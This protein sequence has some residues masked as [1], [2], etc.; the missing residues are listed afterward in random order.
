MTFYKT[1][2]SAVALL[3]SITSFANDGAFYAAGNHL[4]PMY[5]TEISVRKEILTIKRIDATHVQITV[6]YE[7]FN[8]KKDKTIEVGFEAYSPSGDVNATPQKGQHPYMKGFTVNLNGQAVPWKVAIVSDSAY[9]KNGVFKTKTLAAALKES[10]EDRNYVEFFY[11]YHFKALFKEGLNT[12]T[13]TYNL[14]LSSSVYVNYSLMYILSAAGRWAN[15]QIDDFTLQIDMGEFQDISIPNSFFSNVSEWQILGAGKGVRAKPSADSEEKTPVS[16]FFIRK[17]MLVFEK[18]NFKPTG[19]LNIYAYDYYYSHAGQEK[20]ESKQDDLPFSI[21]ND[22]Y[23]PEPA[24]ELSKKILKNLP[25]ARRGYV[26]K[27]ADLQSYFETQKWYVK[28]NSYQPELNKLTPPEQ[29]WV[30]KW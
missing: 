8:P 1:L 30:K 17:G 28:D 16:Q 23:I 6:Y 2:I 14:T 21:D 12:I 11:V 22:R 3:S 10:E 25:F 20:F 18:K 4:I 27:S 5:E 13:H 24:D 26:F 15:R 29:T 9:Y 19:E 7:F